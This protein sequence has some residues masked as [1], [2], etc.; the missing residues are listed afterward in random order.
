MALQVPRGRQ[1]LDEMVTK[2]MKRLKMRES[3]EY[4]TKLKQNVEWLKRL[5]TKDSKPNDG[6]LDVS[7]FNA[8][9]AK[10]GY[11]ATPSIIGYS[12]TGSAI[13]KY[14]QDVDIQ[15]QALS[16]TDQYYAKRFG[17]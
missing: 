7:V 15:E 5:D 1:T 8:K 4:K 2:H 10:F 12:K 6:R 9:V 11:S 14:S 13:P 16:M 17:L 3:N